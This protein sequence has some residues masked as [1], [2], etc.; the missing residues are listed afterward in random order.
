MSMNISKV[1]YKPSIYS[2][3]LCRRI[4]TRKQ[5]LICFRVYFIECAALMGDD[6]RKY[7]EWIEE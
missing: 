7:K 1:H 2:L 3:F 5:N 6:I 4:Y